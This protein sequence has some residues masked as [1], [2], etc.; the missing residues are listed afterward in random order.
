MGSYTGGCSFTIKTLV[1]PSAAMV[2]CQERLSAA[3]KATGDRWL[4]PHLTAYLEELSP[5]YR[6]SEGV[7]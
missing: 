1:H 7:T 6:E 3:L 5:P 4:A 2:G